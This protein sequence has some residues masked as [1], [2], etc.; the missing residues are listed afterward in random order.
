MRPRRSRGRRRQGRRCGSSRARPSWGTPWPPAATGRSRRRRSA[1]VHTPSRRRR[2]MSALNT[3]A[4]SP[5]I[6][7]TVDTTAPAAP[8]T[9]DLDAASDTGSSSTDDVTT[10]TT[11][12]FSGT[13]EAGALVRL[14]DGATE[15]GSGSRQVAPTRSR[16]RRLTDDDY[17]MT[18]TAE[19]AAG[20]VSGASGALAV[21]I[22]ATAPAAPSTPDLDALS[23]SGAS[24]ND[25][26]TSDTT[27]TFSGTA[28][29]GA[30]VRLFDGPTEVG[31][32]TATGGNY[33]ITVSALG[34]TGAPSPPPRPTHS[35]TRPYRARA[36]SSRSMR[37]LRQ[38][39]R[40]RIST[41]A[42]D[43]AREH[44]RCHVGL[45]A[46]V[47][48]DGRGGHAGAPVRRRDR[49]GSGPATGGNYSITTSTLADDDYSITATA[50]D[51]AGNVSRRVARW[52]SR[53]MRARRRHRR[54]RTRCA[55]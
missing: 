9:P 13:A 27:P 53:S 16:H 36:W 50:E 39:R 49:G 19:D 8:S 32:G 29:A 25:N 55:Q 37:R 41:P 52:R 21:T 15:L 20:N 23:D 34:E 45:D 5:G 40:R 35:R 7:I 10:D 42:S 51:T 44:P 31:S 14:F 30:L 3:S 24:D 17:S 2:P 6:T 22:D 48:G 4:P 38:R 47:L 54:R 18:A 33:S 26:I 43:R 46:D 1:V 11:P 12:T 28:E